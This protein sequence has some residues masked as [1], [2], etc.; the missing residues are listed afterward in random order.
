[1]TFAR[2]GEYNYVCVI[3][4]QM[5]GKMIVTDNAAQADSQEQVPQRG[6]QELQQWL[7]EGRAARQWLMSQQPRRTTN[8]D[9]TTIWFAEMGT[10]TE[11]TDV[12]AFTPVPATVQ[13]GDRVTFIN[14]PEAPHTATFLD[15]RS[16]PSSDSPEVGQVLPG[17]S[18]QVLTAQGY[19]NT[20]LLPPIAPPEAVR[21]LT[22]VAAQPGRYTYTCLL[23]APS[24]HGRDH[25]GPVATWRRDRERRWRSAGRSSATTSKTAL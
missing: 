13:A 23:H 21:S 19:F 20:G 8:P 24:G 4:P 10:T 7:Q 14:N 3:H 16:A 11:H 18:P 1:V 6:R 22:F 25:R 9:G 2:P 5:R 17:P 15:G 12:L